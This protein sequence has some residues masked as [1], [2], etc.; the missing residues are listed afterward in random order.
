MHWTLFPGGE[1]ESLRQRKQKNVLSSFSSRL[2]QTETKEAPATWT[3]ASMAEGRT[4]MSPLWLMMTR[5][6][7]LL[8]MMKNLGA[9]GTTS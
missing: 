6:P 2:W 5:Y 8:Y 1:P 3:L 7:A 4:I 9:F